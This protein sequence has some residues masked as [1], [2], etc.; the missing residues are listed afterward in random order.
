MQQDELK[1]NLFVMN[2][3]GNERKPIASFMVT[4]R[5]PPLIPFSQLPTPFLQ[6]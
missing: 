2:I 6:Y 5:Y 3:K 4:K 1:T